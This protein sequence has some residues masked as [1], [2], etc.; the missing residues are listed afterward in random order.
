MHASRQ[1]TPV[2]LSSQDLREEATVTVR[3][4]HVASSES[5]M[6]SVAP[7]PADDGAG[8]SRPTLGL[9]VGQIFGHMW[10]FWHVAKAASMVRPLPHIQHHSCLVN[11]HLHSDTDGRSILMA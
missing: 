9:S 10:N 7:E 4:G 1:A 11:D 3:E 5:G 6:A 2:V 8:R